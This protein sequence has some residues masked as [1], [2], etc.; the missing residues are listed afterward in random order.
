MALEVG[1]WIAVMV[2]GFI[3]AVY[4]SRWAVGHIAEFAA[5]TRIPPFLI[6]IT[7]VSIGTDLPEIATSIVASITGHGDI[8]VG[9]SIGSAT[10]QSTLILG[11][12]PIVA[13]AFPIARGRIARVGAA[14]IGAMLLGALLMMDGELSRFDAVVLVSSWVL[15]T[16]LIWRVLPE[17]A[18]PYVEIRGERH[19][20]HLL[21]A[22]IGLILV[23]LGATTAIEAVTNLAE[24]LEAPEYLIAFLLASLGTSL[25]ELVVDITAVRRGQ[26]DLA[27][28]DA[29]GSSFVDSTLSLAAGPL[30]VP[31]AVTST[32]AV[33]GSIAAA[34]AIGLV[35]MILM[36][37]RIH[38]WKTGSALILVFVA[39]YA[40]LLAIG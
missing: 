36:P 21:L 10:V 4:A 16:F 29:L 19:F 13:G 23:G 35:I 24:L 39:V 37:R 32:I 5:S 28:G 20:K 38:D 7:L 15:G 14:T 25:P 6:G 9:D 34:V 18:R 40:L 1:L 12:L 3:V 11:L 17:D 22:S 2:T 31:I 26:Y 30:F 27:V 33:R 8:I